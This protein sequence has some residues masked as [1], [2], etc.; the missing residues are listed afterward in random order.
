MSKF[1]GVDGKQ[2][3]KSK[4]IEC[5]LSFTK[6]HAQVHTSASSPRLKSKLGSEG[7][8]GKKRNWNGF[9]KTGD[10]RPQNRC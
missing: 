9:Q 3:K 8:D 7:R 6:L 4:V 1:T 5:A 10:Q 2:S